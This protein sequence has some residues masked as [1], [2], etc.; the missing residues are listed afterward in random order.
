MWDSKRDTDIS[1]ST[2]IPK[3]NN[4]EQIITVFETGSII[5]S[6]KYILDIVRKF[7]NEVIEFELVEKTLLKVRV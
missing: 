1:I 4:D 3:N 7:D 5:I 6:C 2:F